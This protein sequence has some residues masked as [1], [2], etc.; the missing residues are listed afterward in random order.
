MYV[1][2]DVQISTQVLWIVHITQYQMK[3]PRR[4]K[5][6][7]IRHRKSFWLTVHTLQNFK[8][9]PLFRYIKT[10]IENV[11]V[12]CTLNGKIHWWNTEGITTQ[13]NNRA[14]KLM[15]LY[16]DR[17]STWATLII[18]SCADFRLYLS[19]VKNPALKITNKMD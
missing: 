15:L 2:N 5:P 1:T 13:Q 7:E 16:I 6:S 19:N 17:S 10:T 11:L 12:L 14:N 8:I 18:S 9:V 4:V 3:T